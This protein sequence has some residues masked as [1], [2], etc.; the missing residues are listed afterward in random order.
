MSTGNITF[1]IFIFWSLVHRTKEEQY[2]YTH[3]YCKIYHILSNIVFGSRNEYPEIS[4]PILVIGL[5]G[6]INSK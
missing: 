6:P 3:V 5:R 2:V 4:I 1:F